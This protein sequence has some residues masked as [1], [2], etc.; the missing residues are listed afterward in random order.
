LYIFKDFCRP[1]YG[2]LHFPASILKKTEKTRTFNIYFM[3]VR[4]FISLIICLFPLLTIA[5][6]QAADTADT[7][8]WR[9]VHRLISIKNYAQTLPLLNQIKAKAEEN[10]NRGDWIRAVMAENLSLRVNNTE[11][12]SFVFVKNHLE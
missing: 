10:N 11:D 8:T 12:D 3:I 6:K 2:I 9:E 1:P 7:G 5:Q 4:I